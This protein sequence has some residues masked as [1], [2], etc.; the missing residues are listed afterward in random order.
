DQ[1]FFIN[2]VE[3]REPAGH[4]E[5]V[6]AERRRMNNATV[7]SAEG[8]LINLAPGHDRPAGDVAAAQTFRQGDDVRLQIPVLEPEH[9]PGPSKSSLDFVAN[10]QRPVLSAKLLSALEEVRLRRLAA[11]SLDGFDDK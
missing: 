8:F 1:L 9:F 10:E 5:I 7:H 11:F 4:G 6:P 2:H 3:G